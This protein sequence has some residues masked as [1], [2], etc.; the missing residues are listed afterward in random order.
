MPDVQFHF[1]NASYADQPVYHAASMAQE[2]ITSG[3]SAVHT[4]VTAPDSDLFCRVQVTGVGEVY[5]AIGVDI[6]ASEQNGFLVEA[7]AVLDIGAIPL[8]SRGSVIDKT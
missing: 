6:V 3:A 8:G 7:P 5:V 2:T 1:G 4:T